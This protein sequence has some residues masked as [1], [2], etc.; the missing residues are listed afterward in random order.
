[1]QSESSKSEKPKAASS[2][3][4]TSASAAS[5]ANDD[6]KVVVQKRGGFFSHLAAG[7]VGGVLALSA[8][9]WVLPQLGLQETEDQN[10]APF[11]ALG[12]SREGSGRA[13]SCTN[14]SE[15]D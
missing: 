10:S 12:R 2:A 7:V 1:M 4:A 6:A 8:Y 11:A 9:Q 14:G 3:S 13:C 5:A 15:W